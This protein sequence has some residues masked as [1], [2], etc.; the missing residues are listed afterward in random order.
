M[1]SKIIHWLTNNAHTSTVIGPLDEAIQPSLVFPPLP[2]IK[3]ASSSVIFMESTSW[4]I[5]SLHRISDPMQ[6]T[7]RFEKSMGNALSASKLHS[8]LV[9]YFF[10]AHQT[11]IKN[12]IPTYHDDMILWLISQKPGTCFYFCWGY[13]CPG[14]QP[15]KTLQSTSSYEH[16]LNVPRKFDEWS[17]RYVGRMHLPCLLV[18]TAAATLVDVISCSIPV[19]ETQDWGGARSPMTAPSLPMHLAFETLNL[20][21]WNGKHSSIAKANMSTRM[22]ASNLRSHPSELSIGAQARQVSWRPKRDW[23]KPNLRRR[24]L[25][26]KLSSTFCM[27]H[28]LLLFYIPLCNTSVVCCQCE[29]CFKPIPGHLMVRSTKFQTPICWAL[30]TSVYEKKVS[31]LPCDPWWLSFSGPAY[32]RKGHC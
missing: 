16:L 17:H 28:F 11:G 22:T 27:F 20:R 30:T 5:R 23:P 8:H 3:A 19:W 25:C 32:T 13:G 10:P 9:V 29:S 2:R 7:G 15:K 24:T 31:K 14:K 1:P 26:S 6:T 12:D 21:T 4:P 18:I